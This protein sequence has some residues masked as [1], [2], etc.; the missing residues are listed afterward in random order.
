MNVCPDGIF[1]ISK[2]LTT[3]FGMVMHHH[4]PD[5]LPKWLVC[6]LQGQSHSEGSCDQ[7]LT[8]WYIFWAVDPFAVKLAAHH[9]K[10]DCFVKRL[11]CSVVVEVKVTGKV[12]NFSDCSSGGFL[13]NCWTFCNQTCYGDASSWARVSWKMIGFA[14]FMF[15]AT[16]R[17]HRC[18]FFLPY[19]LN[20]WS[21]CNQIVWYTMIS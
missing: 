8:F 12:Q 16:V 1:W 14:V 5:C 17:A 7:N 15:K 2:P 20:C 9:H 11:D 13:L 4:E 10:L 21:F 6:C 19:L 3:K 18:D